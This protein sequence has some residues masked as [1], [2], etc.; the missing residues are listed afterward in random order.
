MLLV[1]LGMC[2]LR[3]SFAFSLHTSNGTVAMCTNSNYLYSLEVIFPPRKPQAGHWGNGN[4]EHSG[5]SGEIREEPRF[6][7]A[8]PA[9]GSQLGGQ[10]DSEAGIS[11][12]RCTK[13]MAMKRI[14]PGH[15]STLVFRLMY[16]E[17]KLFRP[18]SEG[19]NACLPQA[20]A[21]PG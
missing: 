4:L 21:E 15:K 17:C 7:S 19:V 2:L 1:V 20:Q 3:V 13:L 18:F 12:Y 16:P 9:Q 10:P 11:V 14:L 5:W 6:H 8:W